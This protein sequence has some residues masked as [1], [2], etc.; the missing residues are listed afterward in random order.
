MASALF[1]DLLVL[2]AYLNLT[3]A[4]PHPKKPL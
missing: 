2:P 3:H 1:C 4:K